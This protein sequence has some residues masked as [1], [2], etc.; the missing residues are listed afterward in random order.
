LYSAHWVKNVVRKIQLDVIVF[1]F[2]RLCCDSAPLRYAFICVLFK[3]SLRLSE[4]CAGSH[5][6]SLGGSWSCLA[7]GQYCYFV[8]P[9]G[10]YCFFTFL[11][12]FLNFG[13]ILL[14]SLA[15]K[16]IMIFNNLCYF[17]C[18]FRTLYLDNRKEKMLHN[19]LT[20]PG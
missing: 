2:S 3:Y 16:V 10:Q 18:L 1:F 19:V 11:Y 5:T 9:F 15:S 4:I 14:F 8:L 20:I 12:L 7:P 17:L 6:Q 13:A